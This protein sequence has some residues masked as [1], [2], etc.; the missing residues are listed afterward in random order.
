MLACVG[1]C[2]CGHVRVCADFRGCA[3]GMA[4]CMR[5]CSSKCGPPQVCIGE[6][7]C[8]QDYSFMI[9]RLFWLLVPSYI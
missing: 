1:M 4:G 9:I 3:R 7:G 5:V 6:H 2:R 8:A